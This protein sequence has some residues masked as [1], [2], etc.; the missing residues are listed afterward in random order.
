[1]ILDERY[2]LFPGISNSMMKVFMADGP[3]IYFNTFVD[4][5]KAEAVEFSTESTDIGDLAD[6]LTTTPELFDKYYY[7][8]GDVKLS[9]AQKEILMAAR[10]KAIKFATS[11]GL[12][13]QAALE[14]PSV[15]DAKNAGPFF[16]EAAREYRDPT[17]NEED[18]KKGYQGAWKDETMAAH[19]VEK[20]ASFYNDLTLAAGRKII[21]QS[22]FNI[23][24]RIKEQIMNHDTIGPLFEKP[25]NPDIEVITQYMVTVD[26]NGVMCKI[27]ID[28]FTADH[29]NKVIWPR[30]VK[31][32]LSRKQFRLN[33]D[34][35]NYPYQGSFYS[36]VLAHKY[37]GYTIMPFEFIVACTDTNEEPIIYRMSERELSII[38]DGAVLKS[39]KS[40]MGWMNVLE[41]IK[42][43]DST[44]QWRYPKEYY[45]NGVVIIDS[46]I[47][48]GELEASNADVDIF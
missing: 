9:N 43:H 15:K 40:V 47:G 29:K 19:F 10:S 44:G 46:Y 6:C 20:G 25:T 36:G 24:E 41:L 48:E 22:L 16:V 23:A 37:P 13:A 39:G 3:T 27:L 33:Y 32:A 5:M 12:S 1:M 38:R 8:T 21:D 4:P 18:A 45:D 11:S 31:T 7:I 17:K 34:K 30:D 28:H 42:W 2:K 14:H 26:I 35:Y